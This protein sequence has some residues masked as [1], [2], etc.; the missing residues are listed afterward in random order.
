MSAIQPDYDSVWVLDHPDPNVRFEKQGECVKAGDPVH[1]RHV[2]TCVF[3]GADSNTKYKND[4]GTENEVHCH[5]HATN[6]K[7][8]NLWMEADG[9]ATTDVPSKYQKEENTFII[10]T[11]P[12]A[13]YS[14]PID[15]LQKFDMADLIK[16]IKGKLFSRSCLGIRLLTRIF[17][18]MD[19]KGTKNLDVD[20]FR[21]GLMDYGVQI[22]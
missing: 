15:E 14:R 1:I 9:R 16:E 2:Q 3:L 4:F 22:S 12:D 13:A 10:Q 7:S 20:D 11:A 19:T 18:A 5:N 17:K 21:W 6:F 8:Q